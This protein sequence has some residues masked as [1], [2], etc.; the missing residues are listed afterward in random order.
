MVR[1]LS[2]AVAYHGDGCAE[3]HPQTWP[4]LRGLLAAGKGMSAG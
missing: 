2:I 3:H 4:P 1:G